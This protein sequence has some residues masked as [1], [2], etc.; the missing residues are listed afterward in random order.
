MQ[1]DSRIPELLRRSEITE[2]KLPQHSG[3]PLQPLA[4][5]VLHH[6]RLLVPWLMPGLVWLAHRPWQATAGFLI[7]EGIFRRIDLW[8]KTVRSFVAYGCSN[9]PRYFDAQR[10]PLDP[11]KQYVIAMHPHGLLCC[12]MFNVIARAERNLQEKGCETIFGGRGTIKPVLCVAPAVQWFPFYGEVYGNSCTDGYSKTVRGILKKGLTPAVCPGGFSEACYNGASQDH[13][14]AWLEGRAG[15]IKVAIEAGVDIIPLY[16]FGLDSMYETFDYGRHW[17][18]IKAQ[19]IGIPMVGWRGK[20]GSCVPFTEESISVAMEPF[21]TS[22]YSLD[23]L[24]QACRDYAIYLEKGFEEYK[25]LLPSEK[26]KKLIV[27]G[28]GRSPEMV[29]GF[30]R[31]KL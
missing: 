31:S 26:N 18:A 2:R 10:N 4:G 30:S 1:I 29:S 12:G 28:S 22:K 3:G 27:I 20:Y 9:L 7:Y 13:E 8:N 11:S 19:K 21:P 25:H 6:V 16:T 14:F 23:E 24:S 17:R 5:A 15:F